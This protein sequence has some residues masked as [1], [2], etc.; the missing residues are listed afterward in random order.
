MNSKHNLRPTTKRLRLLSLQI[1]PDQGMGAHS[2]RQAM[3]IC[4]QWKSRSNHCEGS[5]TAVREILIDT[6]NEKENIYGS[7]SSS[8]I[9][10]LIT[11]LWE[12]K[13]RLA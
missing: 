11:Q 8:T 4:S 10:R 7:V 9:S 3:Y 2:S 13:V 6:E 5:L 1:N 12:D